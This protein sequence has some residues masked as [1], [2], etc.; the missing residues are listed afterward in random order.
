MWKMIL[1]YRGN[2]YQFNG[3]LMP[4]DYCLHFSFVLPEDL[5]SSMLFLN[6]SDWAKPKAFVQYSIKA[7][8]KTRSWFGRNL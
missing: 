2:C 3:D 7:T 5:P 4:G 8:L 1:D 6:R